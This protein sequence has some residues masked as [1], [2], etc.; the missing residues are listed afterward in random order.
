[1][2]EFK[3][4]LGNYP[5]ADYAINL[6]AKTYSYSS[7]SM[8][9]WAEYKSRV[10]AGEKEGKELVDHAETLRKRL[11]L[12]KEQ[13]QWV[14]VDRY[15]HSMARMAPAGELVV[16]QEMK[17]S[18]SSYLE[19]K[20]ESDEQA[21]AVLSEFKRRYESGLC[22]FSLKSDETPVDSSAT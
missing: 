15:L 2:P 6:F 14:N 4:L 3:A 13:K 21:L 17:E 18:L 5:N 19:S 8:A 20:I 9:V 22:E 7:L 11:S 12:T 10:E 16:S 1:M